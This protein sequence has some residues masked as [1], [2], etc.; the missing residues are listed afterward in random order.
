MKKSA[1]A[2]LAFSFWVCG[3]AGAQDLASI[4]G[5]VSDP[6]GAVIA[7]AQ[8]TVA[9]AELGL[10]RTTS[11]NSD[12]EYSVVRVPIGNY[13]VTAEKSGFEKL[14]RTGI[15]LD[16]G[17]TLRV[18]LQL[19]VGS[20]TQE[21]VVTTDAVRVETETGALSHVV[22]STQVAELN[23]ES[24][25]FATLA[26]LIPGAAPAGTGFDPTST[27]VLANATIA[28]NGVPGN[29]NNWEIDGTNNVDQGSGSNSLM[30]YP[31]IDSISEFRISTSNYS[32]EYGKSGGANI[33][34]VTKS[35]TNKFHGDLFEFVRNDAFDANDWFLNQAG[36][37]R[38]PLKRN[39]FGFTI[40]GPVY[41]PGHY[42]TNR[43]KTFFFVSEEWRTYRQGTVVNQV[44][45]SPKERQGD[46]SEC[47]PASANYDPVVAVPLQGGGQLCTL[48]INPGTGLAYPN[49]VV[50][51]DPTAAALLAALIP[52]PNSGKV[53]YR[54]APSLPTYIHE[55]M[56]KIDHNFSEKLRVF[57]RYTQDADNQDFIP[58]LWSSANYATVK[59]RWTSPAISSVLHITQSI[60]PNLLNE[61]ILSY[62]ADVNTVHNF[63]G[64]DSPS[65]SINKP[66]GFSMQTIFP[67][68]QSQ[69][70]LPGI[71]FNA[72][73]PFLTAESTGFEFDFVD[74]QIAVKD[75]LIWS[76][77]HHTFKTGFFLLDNHINTTTNIG[78][79]TE[80]F[81]SF[82]NSSIS[83][84]NA[85][86]DMFTGNVAQYQEYGRVIGGQLVGGPGR[87]RWRQW[88]F[89]P[90]VQDDWRVSPRL[91][92]N[93]GVR[94]LW[95][96]PFFDAWNPTNDSI[97]VP[98]FYNPA[99]QAQLDVNGNLI[100]G[101]GANYLTY[102]NGL[103]ECGVAPIPKGCSTSYHGTVSPRFGFS[104]DPF[105]TGKTAVRGGYALNWDSSNPLHAGAGFNGNP[106]TN[107]NLSAFN[108]VG[109]QNIG[110]GPLGTVGFSDI[111]T[112]RLWPEVEQYSLG[113]QHE[114]PGHTVLS[115]SYVGSV[116]R[117]L[118]NNLNINAVP[119]GSTTQNVPA[120]A[121]M[122][123]PM[124]GC[125]AS[126]NCNVQTA[127]IN[128]V[129][130][131]FFA[132]YRGFTAITMRAPNGNSNYNSLQADL[133]HSVGHGLTFEAAYTWSHTLDNIVTNGV[134][135]ANLAR[136][137]GTSSLNQAHVLVINWVYDMPFFKNSPVAAARYLLAGWQLGGIASFMTGPPIDFS[138]SLNGFSTGIGGPVVC[139][140]LGKVAVKKGTIVDPTFGPT[141]SWFDPNAVGQVTP[142]QL[143][144]NNQPGMFGWM[145]RDPLRGPG[146]NNWDIA[147]MRNFKFG[148]ERYKLQFRLETF[149]TFNHPQWSG[150][151]TACN[152]QSPDGGPC[153]GPGSTFGEVSSAY[154]SRI[155]Q[156]GLKFAF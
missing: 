113:I 52:L 31:S 148:A 30:L 144:A 130:A 65:G 152:D 96:T 48:P 82:G 46:F 27:G 44:V 77:G 60:N 99:Q 147:L 8:V 145:R 153:G 121:G 39:N 68:N 34:V 150:V 66:Q 134:E 135:D 71:Q 62:S 108:V 59:S 87:G 100:P 42:N 155:V 79:N 35:G 102:G 105:G 132:P 137:Y 14:L 141:P 76:R 90:Y 19:K 22:N 7:G 110:P 1:L 20:A 49:D 69:P 73:V 78:L 61:V 118:Q 146:R 156:L 88:D 58:T 109:F 139:D 143:L 112:R 74:P 63:T 81:L 28:F 3:M 43:T 98:S 115:V 117:H 107:A 103:L 142:D 93:L 41:I 16:A 6:S 17:Q 119:V 18:P 151:N 123:T 9:N 5:T 57:A 86:A 26:T 23:L 124:P 64:F 116:G 67:G 12:G 83:T 101:S 149:N 2:L 25:N 122:S 138:C 128:Q 36:Q 95:L 53:A 70:K 91:T 136:W 131:I 38:Q 80:G 84:G 37:P 154:Q 4:V 106:P 97:F 11:S 129:P 21:L 29:F 114:F 111:P 140:P 10:I 47:D 56:V 51:I 40:G 24:R 54:T 89:E 85:L 94:Y 72:G 125:D 126:G 13:T 32:A 127:L 92:L 45:P 120:F 50:P 133:R 15:A 33:E 104:W 75:N 55:D